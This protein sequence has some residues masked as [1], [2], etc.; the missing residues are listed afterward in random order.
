M[1]HETNSAWGWLDGDVHLIQ[2]TLL[3][4]KEKWQNVKQKALWT[5]LI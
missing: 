5:R 3:L 4:E 1:F 2:L